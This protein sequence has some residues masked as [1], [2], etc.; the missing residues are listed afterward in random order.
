MGILLFCLGICLFH[1]V[2]GLPVIQASLQPVCFS[3]PSRRNQMYQIRKL[4]FY[5]CPSAPFLI[6][7]ENLGYISYILYPIWEKITSFFNKVFFFLFFRS[8]NPPVHKTRGFQSVNQPLLS[9]ES[10]RET[11]HRKSSDAAGA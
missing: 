5:G 1:P 2:Y 6:S 7:D 9:A 11:P 3:A 4:L 10:G 8:K